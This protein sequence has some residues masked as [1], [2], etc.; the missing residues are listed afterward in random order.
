MIDRETLRA[1]GRFGEMF[2]FLKD[3]REVSLRRI[4][5]ATYVCV[6]F[7]DLDSALAHRFVVPREPL[8]VPYTVLWRIITVLGYTDALNALIRMLKGDISVVH[9][10]RQID[11]YKEGSEQYFKD[12]FR[13]NFKDHGFH[14]SFAPIFRNRSNLDLA[15]EI[16]RRR[17]AAKMLT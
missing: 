8:T 9:S 4:L 11:L 16:D 14:L 1:R 5:G 10:G 13:R 15:R 12:G 17:Q 2:V 6:T 7:A 3:I